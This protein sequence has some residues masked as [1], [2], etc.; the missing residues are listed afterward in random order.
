MKEIYKILYVHKAIISP[1]ELKRVNAF[2]LS[3]LCR[4]KIENLATTTKKNS[5]FFLFIITGH[6]GRIEY[7]IAAG[8]DNNDF[9]IE[10]NGT[11]RTKRVLDRETIPTYN[12]VVTAKD[13]A[14][15]PEKR[16]SST[17]Q[18]IRKKRKKRKQFK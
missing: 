6:N 7:S 10:R 15:E 5:Y 18:V 11:I 17:V 12:L 1:R 13:C 9:E 14:H 16:L 3:C 8:D 4:S 2:Y